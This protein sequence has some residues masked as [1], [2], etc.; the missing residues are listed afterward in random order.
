MIACVKW[1]LQSR[2]G[3]RVVGV[4]RVWRG[5]LLDC[6]GR[7]SSVQKSLPCF[8]LP[9]LAEF[10]VLCV[11]TGGSSGQ[12]SGELH[13]T[14]HLAMCTCSSDGVL[15]RRVRG[16]V[17]MVLSNRLSE[18]QLRL[19]QQQLRRRSVAVCDVNID[20]FAS[21]V[22]PVRFVRVSLVEQEAR[23][24]AESE[25]RLRWQS[26]ARYPCPDLFRACN[27]TRLA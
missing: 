8:V 3:D 11:A 2:R 25:A 4:G 14:S 24:K 23:A 13:K 26:Q 27:C 17:W 10:V 5:R 16:F 9:R 1:G 22:N 15:L 19:Q 18:K 7:D 20:G 12:S 6:L 21:A